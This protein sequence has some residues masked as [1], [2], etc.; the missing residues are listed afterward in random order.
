M[1]IAATIIALAVLAGCSGQQRSPKEQAAEDAKAIAASETPAFE[2]LQP[3]EFSDI[4]KNKLFGASCAFTPTDKVDTSDGGSAAKGMV[5]L[6]MEDGAYIKQGDAMVSFTPDLASTQQA[7]NTYQHYTGTALDMEFTVSGEGTQSGIETSDYDAQLALRG[8]DGRI[9]YSAAG[10][11][12][13][14]T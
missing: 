13:C 6:A 14:G 11:A 2:P 1:R 12:Q 8:K 3:I 4:D 9:V 5:M 7:M 10:T